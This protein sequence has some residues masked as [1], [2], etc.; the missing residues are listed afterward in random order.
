MNPPGAPVPVYFFLVS[1]ENNVF[2]IQVTARERISKP[3]S[4]STL[5]TPTALL[6]AP[7]LP[8]KCRKLFL[9]LEW[10]LPLPRAWLYH[11]NTAKTSGRA[12]FGSELGPALASFASADYSDNSKRKHCHPKPGQAFPLSKSLCGAFSKEGQ[13]TSSHLIMTGSESRTAAS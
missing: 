6:P 3:R 9:Y 1:T 8:S 5:Y 11:R 12:V 7:S 10:A 4:P 2:D 13:Q